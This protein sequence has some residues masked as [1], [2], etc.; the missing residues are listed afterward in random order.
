MTLHI[1]PFDE[2]ISLVARF[3]ERDG[4]SATAI[5]NLHVFKGSCP[6]RLQHMAYKPGFSLI[7][8][9]S[10]RLMVG[11]DVHMYGAGEYVLTSLDLPVAS[12][13]TEATPDIPYLCFT[14]FIDSEKLNELLPRTSITRLATPADDTRGL[15]V[16]IAPPDLLDAST[17]LLRL[18]DK[19]E[20]IPVMAPLIERE[21]S[22]RLLTGPDGPRLLN[23]M[24]S[25][26]QSHK[27]LRA[28][29]WLRT[30]FV[31][32]LRIEEL[33]EH[34]SMSVSSLHHHFKAVTAM[35]PMQYQ[36]QLRLH[37]ARR[38]LLTERLDVGTAGYRVG[39][40][41]PSQFSREYSRLY[42]LPPLKDIEAM[43]GQI[44]AE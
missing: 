44:A 30:N 8:Q 27:V 33:A 7:L 10:K 43:R 13:V 12:H 32:S 5:E 38:L 24:L 16:N 39:Y 42:G 40:Q 15:V 18:L 6:T 31:Q 17:R 34:V 23:M 3:A 28:V 25:E 37:E 22:Y 9:G 21:I 35:T 29:S 14:L 19:P 36:K 4:D 2:M 20:D 11:S 41:S 26:S 1:G